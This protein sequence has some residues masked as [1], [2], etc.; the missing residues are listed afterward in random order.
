MSR[1]DLPPSSLQT[2][3]TSGDAGWLHVVGDT[4]YVTDGRDGLTMLDV[5]DPLAPAILS[6]YENTR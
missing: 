6:Q 1:T 2:V 4:L 5:S 3:T